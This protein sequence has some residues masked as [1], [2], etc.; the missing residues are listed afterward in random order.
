MESFP[1]LAMIKSLCQLNLLIAHHLS[2]SLFHPLLVNSDHAKN[3]LVLLVPGSHSLQ[4]LSLRHKHTLLFG[5][6]FV[7]LNQRRTANV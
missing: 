4:L 7:L 1:P 2:L 3:S 6:D 5:L